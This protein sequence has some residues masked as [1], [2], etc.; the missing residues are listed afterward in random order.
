MDFVGLTLY[1]RFGG[2]ERLTLLVKTFYRIMSTDPLARDCF[3]THEGKDIAHSAEKLAMFLSG[4]MGGPQSYQEKYGHPRLRMRHMP[5]A[6]GDKEA[7]Q[8]LYCM[9]KAM[10]EVKVPQEVQEEMAPYFAQV[11]GHLRNR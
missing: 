5:F 9:K 4:I 3:A 7:E 10:E 8:W 11:T 1:E 6:I 2:E